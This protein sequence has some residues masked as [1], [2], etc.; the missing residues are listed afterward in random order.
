VEED[1]GAELV[2]NRADRIAVRKTA[3]TQLQAQIGAERERAANDAG[4]GLPAAHR[5]EGEQRRGAH[6][7]GGGTCQALCPGIADRFEHQCVALIVAEN[8]GRGGV[9]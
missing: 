1:G 3:F 8:L 7:D 9:A 2:S 4:L 6:P 5:V